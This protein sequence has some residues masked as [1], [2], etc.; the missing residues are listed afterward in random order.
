MKKHK[1][2]DVHCVQI[3]LGWLGYVHSN[4]ITTDLKEYP[5]KLFNSEHSKEN[6][7]CEAEYDVEHDAIVFDGDKFDVTD[8]D[9]QAMRDHAHGRLVDNRNYL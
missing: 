7:V 3:K 8:E 2:S 6:L 5:S 1:T 9:I 4:V